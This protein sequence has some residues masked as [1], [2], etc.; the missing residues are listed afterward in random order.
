MQRLDRQ[1]TEL[2]QADARMAVI[3]EKLDERLDD[4][5]SERKQ[6]VADFRVFV[7]KFG[8]V[9]VIVAGAGEIVL[10]LFGPAIRKALGLP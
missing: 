3:I 8:A 6:L 5:V 7:A 4:E 9:M 10:T 1:L 2:T